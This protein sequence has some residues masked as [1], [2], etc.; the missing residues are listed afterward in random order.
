MSHPRD[1]GAPSS[2]TKVADDAQVLVGS[3]IAGAGASLLL[4][5]REGYT[6]SNVAGWTGAAAVIVG[7]YLAGRGAIGQST[8]KIADAHGQAI[9]TGL[10]GSGNVAGTAPPP[11]MKIGG[12]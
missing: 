7:G 6:P 5:N 9:G 4:G 3:L 11:V 2:G 12:G 8:S 10:V 1:K